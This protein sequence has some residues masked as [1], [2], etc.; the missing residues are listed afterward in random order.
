MPASMV[1]RSKMPDDVVTIFV[2]PPSAPDLKS[3]LVRR[4]ES[5]ARQRGAAQMVLWSDTRFTTAHRLYSRLGY[6]RIDGQ[7]QLA[8]IS[9]SAEYRFEKA[10]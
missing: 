10:L 7:R 4:A 5:H 6:A 1:V 3:R 2:L 9:Q 8:D